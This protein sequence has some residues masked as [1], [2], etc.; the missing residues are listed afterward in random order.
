MSGKSDYSAEEWSL[1]A[2]SPFMTG[3]IVSLAS[4]SGITG[5]LSESMVVSKA[6]LA[7]SQGQSEHTLLKDLVEDIKA[8]KG[9]I[10]KAEGLSPMNAKT[11]APQK[12][13]QVS[14]LL[15]Q[16]ATPEEATAFKGWLKDIAKQSAEAAK[17]GGFF[18]I[19]GVQVSDTEKAALEQINTL[20]G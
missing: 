5:V 3:L 18:G 20:L 13:Q 14:V 1:L 12:L 10:A 19:G 15:G 6:L 17:E 9:Q 4:P 8:S 7:A 16:K 2:Q 11:V